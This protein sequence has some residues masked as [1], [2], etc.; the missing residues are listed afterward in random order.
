MR[1]ST[2]EV[3][4]YLRYLRLVMGG[5]VTYRLSSGRGLGKDVRE[6]KG[7]WCV[8]SGLCLA[9]VSSKQSNNPQRQAKIDRD[10]TNT[11]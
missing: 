9:C 11:N 7:G 6:I 8:V 1:T 3:S 4:T 10:G 5:R 2:S